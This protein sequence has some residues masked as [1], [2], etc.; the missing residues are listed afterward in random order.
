MASISAPLLFL[1][2]ELLSVP[3]PEIKALRYRFTIPSFSENFS[4][5][6]KDVPSPF[7]DLPTYAFL[8]LH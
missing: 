3:P 4:T 1:C 2:R 7:Q 6:K 5:L 8:S